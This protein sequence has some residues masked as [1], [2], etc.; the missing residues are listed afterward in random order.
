MILDFTRYQRNL[1]QLKVK[2]KLLKK[3]LLS[4]KLY[5][6]QASAGIFPITSEL[7]TQDDD[8]NQILYSLK[9]DIDLE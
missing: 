6:D 3:H 8:F 2:K 9:G 5:I 4:M 7:S 1:S